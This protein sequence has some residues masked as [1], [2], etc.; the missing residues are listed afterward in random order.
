MTVAAFLVALAH[1]VNVAV[2][3]GVGVSLLRRSPGLASAYGGDTPA[4]R[5]LACAYLAIAAASL[6]ALVC[7]ASDS[8]LA[9]RIAATLFP[10]QIA[11][12]TM[13]LAALGPGHP[14]VRANLAV[15]VVLAAASIALWM[16]GR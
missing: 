12:K 4:S 16:E 5:I 13:T 11:Y 6:V 14:V 10:L 3:G 8:G 2:A 15:A 7:Y 1:L 9:L